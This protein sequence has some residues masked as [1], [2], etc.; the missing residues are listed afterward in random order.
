MRR[1]HTQWAREVPKLKA[2]LKDAEEAISTKNQ[3]ISALEGQRD[4]L[5]R[6]CEHILL[7]AYEAGA[8]PKELEKIR[9]LIEYVPCLGQSQG[10]SAT[11]L[12]LST[13]E[14]NLTASHA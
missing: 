7:L 4:K 3:Q 8:N 12:L 2:E 1:E 10:V 14:Q 5:M 9:G 6:A 11:A 13:T